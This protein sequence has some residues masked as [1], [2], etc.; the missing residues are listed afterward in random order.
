MMQKLE[1]LYRK[2]S[3]A[4]QALIE[5][6]ISQLRYDQEHHEEFF[7][8]FE[9]LIR[10]LKNAGGTI[11]RKRKL[12]YLII[13]LPESLDHLTETIDFIPEENRT[14]DTLREKLMLRKEIKEDAK[15]SMNNGGADETEDVKVFS[16]QSHSK[17]CYKCHKRGHIAKDC[18]TSR[19][20]SQSSQSDQP[21]DGSQNVQSTNYRG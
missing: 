18:P 7:T 16:V 10:D 19:N 14:L 13:A 8:K 2:K 1:G 21:R 12:S 20:S 11:D 17:E 3:E 9:G 4:K 6:R 15:L 5:R